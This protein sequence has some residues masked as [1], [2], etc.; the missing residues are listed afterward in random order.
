MPI[1][2]TG[3]V[4]NYDAGNTASYP[5]SGT[6]WTN[7]VSGGSNATLTNG[8]T[9]NSGNGGSI[10]LD[11]S[12]DYIA[13]PTIN[14]NASFTFEFW[15]LQVNE[16]AGSTLMSGPGG[17]GNLQI[18]MSQNGVSLV[19]SYTAELGGF[20]ASSGT[21]YNTINHIVLTRSGT[22]Y[23]CYT[24][25]TSRGTLTINQ[26]YNTTNLALGIN[27]NNS[28]PFNGRIYIFR[29]YST[30]LSAADVTQ[31]FNALRGR[32]GV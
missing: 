14:T 19:K 13:L 17:A 24:N 23:T 12:N 2:T 1:I 6:T 29:Q 4:L 27:T 20:G 7:L 3:L 15:A 18:R 26:T 11:G 31:N 8:P 32:F 25:G 5:G 30:V 10:V 16:S 28:E 21:V 22:T 9:F